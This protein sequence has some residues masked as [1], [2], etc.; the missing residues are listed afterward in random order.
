MCRVA[1]KK[2]VRGKT[3]RNVSKGG[4]RQRRRDG[5]VRWEMK[6]RSEQAK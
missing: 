1:K 3:E 6:G 5:A 2:T 4:E